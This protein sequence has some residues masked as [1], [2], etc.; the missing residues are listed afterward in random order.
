MSRI[1]FLVAAALVSACAPK[2]E[3]PPGFQGGFLWDTGRSRAVSVQAGDTLFSVSR[4]YNVPTKAIIARNGL[5]P[6]YELTVGQQLILD[7]T[8]T[9]KV[10]AG[11]TLS[12]IARQYG[13]EMR[14]IA[15]ANDIAAPYV[16]KI[17]QELW[18][19]DPFTVAA[20]PVLAGALTPMPS[21]PMPSPPIPNGVPVGG[22]SSPR[23]I[24]V[25]SLPPPPGQQPAGEAVPPPPA[26]EPMSMPEPIT[27]APEQTASLPPEPKPLAAPPPRA[28]ARFIWPV[29]GSVIAGFG[30]AGKGLHNDGINIAAKPGAPVKAADNGVVAYAGNE[31]KG[32]GNLLLIKHDDGWT[33]AYAHND[34]LL[35]ERGQEVKQ[36]QV[37]ATVGRT[38]NVDKPQLHFE[39]RR[40]TFAL[41][42]LEHLDKPGAARAG[43]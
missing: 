8:L 4:R 18:I 32:F 10:E 38:G 13:V 17:G 26:T 30:Q 28:A 22:A 31:L 23:A 11:D 37:I 16:I 20:A 39:I 34:K 24:A 9:H 35:V 2:F 27:A 3:P 33:T 14:L 29:E 25:E 43:R 36:G 21:P 12:K 41:D 40:G 42:P 6:P 5:Q 15:E 7:P 19:P 1:A